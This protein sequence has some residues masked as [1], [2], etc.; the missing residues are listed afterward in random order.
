MC[1]LVLLAC[2]PIWDLFDLVSGI[3]ILC[4]CC[5][6]LGVLLGVCFAMVVALKLSVV[7]VGTHGLIWVVRFR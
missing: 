3:L 2:M 1:L 5:D 6:W 7:L 4:L